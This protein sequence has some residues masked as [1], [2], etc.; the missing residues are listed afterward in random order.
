MNESTS[1]KAVSAALK[2]AGAAAEGF[3][4]VQDQVFESL[5]HAT[6]ASLEFQKDLFRMWSQGMSAGSAPTD[7]WM[8]VFEP[9]QDSLANSLDQTVSSTKELLDTHASY[10][11]A[12]LDGM[13]RL[14]KSKGMEEL[15]VNVGAFGDTFFGKY[16]EI[17]QAQ[18][19][20]SECLMKSTPFWNPIFGGYREMARAQAE[21]TL[22]LMKVA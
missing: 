22:N 15:R 8:H 7:R 13:A 21:V 14:A 3:R 5:H 2:T 19:T 11:A 16:Q 4:E 6:R 1:K 10:A 9:I 20:M 18:I 12:A 17:L